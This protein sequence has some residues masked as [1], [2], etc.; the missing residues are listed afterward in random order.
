MTGIKRFYIIEHPDT[1]IIRAWQGHRHEQKW[2]HVIAGAFKMAIIQPDNWKQPSNILKPEVFILSAT[3]PAVLQVPGGH[4]TGFHALEKN[5]KMIIFSNATV[6]ESRKDDYR[7]DE[8]MWPGVWS[9]P[10]PS[11]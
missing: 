11:G 10:C 2:F 6:E 1:D 5:S 8:S 3:H 4:A 7:F 9:H